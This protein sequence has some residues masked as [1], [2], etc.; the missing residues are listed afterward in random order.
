MNQEQI[1]PL[2]LPDIMTTKEVADKLKIES[3]TVSKWCLEKKFPNAFRA[4]RNW[5]IP[6][7]D[8]E[9]FIRTGVK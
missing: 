1:S 8:V 3:G 7:A 6:R 9:A 2:D 4:G 5:R